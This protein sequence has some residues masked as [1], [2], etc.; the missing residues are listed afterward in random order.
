MNAVSHCQA[1]PRDNVTAADAHGGMLRDTTNGQHSV[2]PP[3]AE[4]TATSLCVP[5]NPS[6]AVP[7]SSPLLL[8]Y[9]PTDTPD[10]DA[11]VRLVEELAAKALRQA[12]KP[13]LALPPV[14]QG[15]D[16]DAAAAGSSSPGVFTLR[17]T[18][19]CAAADVVLSYEFTQREC[20]L[21][22]IAGGKWLIAPEYLRDC[23]AVGVF[24]PLDVY[25][26]C[27]SR[28]PEAA[29]GKKA[30]VALAGMCKH[31]RTLRQQAPLL[32]GAAAM[33]KQPNEHT[34]KLLSSSGGGV[35]PFSSCHVVLFNPPAEACSALCDVVAVGGG[36][37][38][39]VH[40]DAAALDL[41]MCDK[42]LAQQQQRD[43]AGTADALVSGRASRG[44]TPMPAC[45]PPAWVILVPTRAA[46]EQMTAMQPLLL[47]AVRTAATEQQRQQSSVAPATEAQSA[48][49]GEG[50]PSASDRGVRLPPQPASWPR[51]PVKVS[52]HAQD[53][54]TLMLQGQPRDPLF[55]AV[56]GL[57]LPAP[58]VSS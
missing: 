14:P 27:P 29:R 6:S 24:L 20:V 3:D 28:L 25:E 49:R 26:W 47:A 40:G 7:P 13:T 2:L 32:T 53:W 34:G 55:T 19:R 21:L 4:A 16:P 44:S 57:P 1:P 36:H 17:V 41:F 35:G 5:A 38:Y 15:G 9:V 30:L 37:A 52:V 10:R 42:L 12:A 45:H 31:W 43:A 56:A 8:L 58:A 39:A 33:A 46:W 54:L 23:R 18:S 11:L 22:A 51:P 48:W 50:A